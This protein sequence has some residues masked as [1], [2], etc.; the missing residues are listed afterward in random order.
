MGFIETLKKSLQNAVGSKDQGEELATLGL[1]I[2][3][4]RK[5]AERQM[6]VQELFD[7]LNAKIKDASPA[8]YVEE[9]DRRLDLLNRAIHS[10]A[11]PYYRSGTNPAFR[12]LM[13]G[14][15][16]WNALAKTWINAVADRVKAVYV[17]DGK[18]KD[19]TDDQQ[20]KNMITVAASHITAINIE[21][22]VKRLHNV[23]E[24][25]VFQDG[26]L[27]LAESY[28]AEDVAPSSATVVQTQGQHGGL[29]LS[30][31]RREDA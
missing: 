28:L 11:S 10:M 16:L 22:L 20:I 19:S 24:M 21:S 27:V 6:V 9:L 2:L 3:K 17:N 30:K 26:M 13:E 8:A 25:H 23:L 15:T 14:W 12:Q 18:A 5:L 7:D 4:D 1:R 31:V 29:D